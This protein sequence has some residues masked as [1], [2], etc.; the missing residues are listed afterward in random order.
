MNHQVLVMV[1][2]NSIIYCH[3]DGEPPN[4]E[5]MGGL[6]MVHY[7]VEITMKTGGPVSLNLP[8]SQRHAHETMNVQLFWRE[9][10][11]IWESHWKPWELL[12]WSLQLTWPKIAH[13]KIQ[14]VRSNLQ[15]RSVQNPGWWLVG[16]MM[17]Q[18]NY[19]VFGA[20]YYH[21]PERSIFWYLRIP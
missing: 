4:D 21:N 7:H 18:Q 3:F 11:W 9:Q 10:W 12:G 20:A 14:D 2:C 5:P 13:D 1:R 6:I 15:G 17:I 19:P 16:Q 8:Y